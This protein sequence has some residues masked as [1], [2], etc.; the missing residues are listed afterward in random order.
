MTVK[1]DGTLGIGEIPGI[2]LENGVAIDDTSGDMILKTGDVEKARLTSD[3]KLGIG[4]ASPSESLDIAGGANFSGNGIFSGDVSVKG[5]AISPFTG[6]RNR[7]INGAMEIAQRGTTGTATAP[8]GNDI[9][10]TA[11]RF[12]AENNINGTEFIQSIES[13]EFEGNVKK[14]LRHTITIPV[15]GSESGNVMHGIYQRIEGLNSFDLSGNNITVSFI[16][17]TNV[18]GTYEVNLRCFNSDLQIE[19]SA[20]SYTDTF[21][22]IANEA[23]KIVILVDKL[24]D[25]AIKNETGPNFNITIG[26]ITLDPTLNQSNIGVWEEDNLTGRVGGFNWAAQAGNFIELTELQLEEGT[27]ATPFERR[28]F[29]TELALCQRYYQEVRLEHRDISSYG[30]ARKIFSTMYPTP[31]RANPS[32]LSLTGTNSPN[33]NDGHSVAGKDYMTVHW[34]AATTSLQGWAVY[35]LAIAKLEAEI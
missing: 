7:I 3:G 2:D 23:K 15:T 35:L 30:G 28:P 22:A 20:Y 9:Y 1:I 33:I 26:N 29:G 27:Q 10:K 19:D 21:D 17:K 13:I 5:G 24:P 32:V 4:T 6:F 14:T 31:M 18:T 12:I 16:F 34:T 25:F 8:T 11:D